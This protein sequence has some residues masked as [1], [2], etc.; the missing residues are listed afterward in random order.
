MITVL[1]SNARMGA[2]S[3]VCL[4]P[5]AGH[6]IVIDWTTAL[7]KEGSSMCRYGSAVTE[8]M[9]HHVGIS[10]VPAVITHSAPSSPVVDLHT[11][12]AVTAT[13]YQSEVTLC[14]MRK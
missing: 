11:S 1:N 13:S 8:L 3:Q 6:I 2:V 5:I 9:A 12:P 10:N 4:T 14:G 7:T